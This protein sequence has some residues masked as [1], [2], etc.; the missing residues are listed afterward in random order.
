MNIYLR[1]NIFH[2]ISLFLSIDKYNKLQFNDTMSLFFRN[3]VKT[4]TT[5]PV[6]SLIHTF[7]KKVF[8]DYAEAEQKLKQKVLLPGEV[9][10]AYYKDPEAEHGINVIFAVGPL[11]N[12]TG[13]TIFKNS[14]EINKYIHEIVDIKDEFLQEIINIKEEILNQYKFVEL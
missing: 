2:K 10:F 3:E 1:I 6:D 14:D 9:A 12:G 7:N 8:K 11:K 13:N 5:Y 4:N